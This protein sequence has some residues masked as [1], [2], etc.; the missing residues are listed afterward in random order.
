MFYWQVDVL[1]KLQH[2]PQVIKFIEVFHC[3][4]HTILVTEFLP[5]NIKPDKQ[6]S[7]RSVS[8]SWMVSYSTALQRLLKL[9]THVEFPNNGIIANR[10][11]PDHNIIKTEKL[12]LNLLWRPVRGVLVRD[13]ISNPVLFH[14]RLPRY[15][16]HCVC[17]SVLEESHQPTQLSNKRKL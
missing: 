17:H 12:S 15:T 10:K 2:C 11:C 16:L 7:I 13:A 9:T 1:L 14:D 5:G 3:E 8:Y 4:F 6:Q